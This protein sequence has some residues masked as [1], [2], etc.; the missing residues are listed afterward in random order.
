MACVGKGDGYDCKYERPNMFT[1][2]NT[3]SN[4]KSSFYLVISHIIP[5]VHKNCTSPHHSYKAYTL[6]TLHA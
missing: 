4:G 5:V 1:D 6:D 3:V 2:F